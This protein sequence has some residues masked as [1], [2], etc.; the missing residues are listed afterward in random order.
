ML[1]TIIKDFMSLKKTL[2]HFDPIPVL[3]LST[4]AVAPKRHMLYPVRGGG[5]DRRLSSY[6]FVNFPLHSGSPWNGTS[7]TAGLSPENKTQKRM[8]MLWKEGIRSTLL[9][10]P[11]LSFPPHW[12]LPSP[13]PLCCFTV[14]RGGYMAGSYAVSLLWTKVCKMATNRA[15][16]CTVSCHFAT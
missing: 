12:V 13:C 3:C 6:F 16:Q 14:S 7:S 2:N 8:G 1:I 15:L 9:P 11:I 5:R 10:L 4:N